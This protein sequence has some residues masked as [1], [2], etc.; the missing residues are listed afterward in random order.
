[1]NSFAKVNDRHS[2]RPGYGI[3]WLE[4]LVVFLGLPILCWR[5]QAPIILVLAVV[6][7]VVYW[8]LRCD[9]SFDRN[10]LTHLCRDRSVWRNVLLGW[11]CAIPLLAALAWQLH[12][13]SLFEL[14]WHRTALWLL[15]MLAYPIISVGPQEL[16]Y[17]AYFC[18]RYQPLFGT[19]GRMIIASAAAFGFA[20]IVFGN[21]VAVLLTAAGGWLFAQTYRRTKSIPAVALQH[22]LYGWAVF[23]V[24]LGQYFL[25]GTTRFIQ[26]LLSRFNL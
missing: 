15:I 25:H 19:G 10:R 23:T 12:P 16:I 17:R 1:M 3:L 22:M 8:R 9:P 6:A 20:H 24:G 4:L 13:D 21:W 18:H 11:L 5:I 26:D 14:P 7:I 2:A